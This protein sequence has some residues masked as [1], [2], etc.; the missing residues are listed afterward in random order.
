M[1]KVNQIEKA[2]QEIDA[3]K[4]HK[5]IDTYLSK[6]YSYKITSNGTKLAE[7]KPTT[8]TPDSFALLENGK[9]VFI[10]YTTQKKD[11]VNKF[12][13]DL[14]K[15]FNESKTGIQIANIEKVILACNSDLN[16]KETETLKNKCLDNNIKCL[17]LGNSSIATELFNN[18]PSIAQNFLNILIDSRQILDYEDFIQSYNSNNYSTSLNT[19]LLCREKEFENLYSNIESSNITIIT[20]S[21]GIGKTKLALEVCN[22]FA[23]KNNFQFKAILNKGADILD[24]ILTYFNDENTSYLVLIDDANRIHTA[25]EYI[26]GYYG[27]KFQNN[28]LKIVATIRDYAKGKVL[29]LIPQQLISTEF[30]LNVLS[31]DS[32]KT[33]IKNEYSITN[34]IYIERILDIS[35]GNP[36]LAIMASSIANNTNTLESIYD[37]TSLYDEYFSKIK[38][39]LNLFNS[40]NFLLTII[41]VSFFK[42]LDK[43]NS[44]QV[45][46]IENTF[47]ISINDLWKNVKELHHLEIFDLHENEVVKVSD[48]ILSTYLFY[49]IVFVD[50]KIDI[51]IFLEN[52]FPKYKTKFIDILN[53]LLNTFDTQ[54]ILRILKEPVNKLW[55]KYLEDEEKL[56]E[57][58]NS[59]WFLKQTDILSYFNNKISNIISEEFYIEEINFFDR[60]KSNQL[61]DDILEKLSIFKNDTN[62]TIKIAVELLLIYFEKKPSKVQELIYVLTTSYSFKYDSYLYG[63][64]K[65]N[66]VLNTIW[67]YCKNGENELITKLFIQLCTS[68]LKTEFEVTKSKGH[69]IQI[70]RFKLVETDKLQILRD[71]IFNYLSSLY[72]IEKYQKDILEVINNYSKGYGF[73][74]DISEVE[75]WDSENI[76]NFIQENFKPDAY[77]ESKVVQKCLD[78]FDRLEISYDKEFRITFNHPIFILEKKMTLDMFELK[79]GNKDLSE[80]E[81]REV[82]RTELTKLVENYSLSDWVTLFDNCKKFYN[83][84]T[85]NDYKFRN[86]IRELFSILS[87]NNPALYVEVLEEYIK[88][89][90]PFKA[91][92]DLRELINILGKEKSLIL[93]QKHSFDTKNS[94]LFN[95]YQSL[96]DEII[97][98]K[99]IQEILELYKISE[100]YVLPYGLEYIKKYLQIESDIFIYVTQILINRTKNENQPFINT[101]DILFNSHS[102]ISK[103]LEIYFKSNLELLK[104]LY[105]LSVNKNNHFDYDSKGLNILINI[106]NSFLEKYIHTLFQR[107]DYLSSHD[108]HNDFSVLW[109]RDDFEDIFLKLIEIIFSISKEKRVWREGEVLASFFRYPQGK[110]EIHNRVDFVI[111]KYIDKFN[112]DEERISFFFEFI[113]ELSDKKR[114]NFIAYFLEKNS[115]YEVFET[116]SLEPSSKGWSGSRI[117]SLQ[118]EKDF[119]LSLLNYTNSIAFL[120]HK[121]IFE[122][123]ILYIEDEIKRE[124]KNDFIDDY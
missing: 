95:F 13:D 10:E 4:F 124:K 112:Q 55:D 114:E 5:L 45:E 44:L 48:Q 59:F 25:L 105:L 24:D 111:K 33:I 27:D 98:K 71:N 2:L 120:Q 81:A 8:G 65:E 96:D 15:C 90:D 68:Y 84:N 72:K 34:P 102:D 12:L 109:L 119:Y 40:D 101:L 69:Q 28:K 73:R 36:R 3:S 16:T 41:I 35:K 97:E 58:I 100:L 61:N 57:V 92:I 78:T 122:K 115:S 18:Y 6:A 77:N 42:V 67:F 54:Y 79:R 118:K 60:Q 9:Y 116:L 62:E 20:G 37:V 83:E 66:V 30:E 53:P 106:D 91:Y 51:G 76:I 47:N 38:D 11:I 107:K 86:S 70:Q 14:E 52:F 23:E 29:N 108:I 87:K 64:E 75:K 39:E 32:I 56:Y 99:D 63:Y 121:Q 74:Y 94:L 117:P 43:S 113:S 50:K 104:E 80:D 1:S 17:I 31:D 49:K 110:D 21:A 88:L 123:R 89:N 93:L 85:R 103:N 26:Q 19:S 7:D 82:I 22:N 46:L